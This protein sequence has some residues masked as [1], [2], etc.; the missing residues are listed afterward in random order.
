RVLDSHIAAQ[1]AEMMLAVVQIGTGFRAGLP[2]IAVAGKTG[3][4]ELTNKVKRSDEV[5]SPPPDTQ[6]D[7][8]PD[9]DAWF[10]AYA[11]GEKPKLVVS[12]MLVKAGAGGEV[13]APAAREIIAAGL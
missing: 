2:D 8:L 11:P 4:A 1:V 5:N 3:T 9:T 12:V 7:S 6:A 10:V 13:A